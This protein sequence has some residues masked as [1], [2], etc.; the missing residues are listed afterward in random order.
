[1]KREIRFYVTTLLGYAL[2]MIGMFIPPRGVIEASVLYA[3]GMLI[4]LAGTTIGIDI[5]AIIKEIRLFKKEILTP[6]NEKQ[7]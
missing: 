6:D 2:M 7:V 3:S 1:M 5:P 4:I